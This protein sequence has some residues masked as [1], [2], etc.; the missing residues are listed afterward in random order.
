M[1]VT[2][3][4]CQAPLNLAIDSLA[5]RFIIMIS[6]MNWSEESCMM[7]FLLKMNCLNSSDSRIAERS[8]DFLGILLERIASNDDLTSCFSHAAPENG[9]P[10]RWDQTVDWLNCTSF[11]NLPAHRKAHIS[12]HT[13][14]SNRTDQNVQILQNV[15]RRVFTS[16]FTSISKS[17]DR[18]CENDDDQVIA[19]VIC[20]CA[21]KC[22]QDLSP[23]CEKE[24]SKNHLLLQIHFFKS[25]SP[26]DRY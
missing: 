26:A 3:P 2:P 8:S 25:N 10:R 12:S 23:E 4:N 14:A 5:L 6:I 11:L 16:I 17:V 20:M 21:S 1:A 13:T 7:N 15:L 22:D 18:T 24:E 19:K 9:W